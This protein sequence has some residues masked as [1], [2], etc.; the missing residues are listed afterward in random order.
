VVSKDFH[1]VSHAN[2]THRITLGRDGSL[3]AT[4]ESITLDKGQT[5]DDGVRSVGCY[6]S[7]ASAEKLIF[8]APCGHG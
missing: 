2:K 4:R 8:T 6:Q 3:I 5:V 7:L 1:S